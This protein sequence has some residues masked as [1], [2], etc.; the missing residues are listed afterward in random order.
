VAVGVAGTRHLTLVAFLSS[1]CGTC[2]GFWEAFSRGAPAELGDVRLVVVTHGPERESPAEVARL[3]PPAV[4]TV[5]SSA[6]F[7]DYAVPVSPYFIL[8]DGPNSRVAGEGAAATWPQV[9][10]L[11][12]Q[13]TGDS[14]DRTFDLRDSRDRDARAEAELAAAGIGPG[15][16]SLYPAPERRG[17]DR[18]T[19]LPEEA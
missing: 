15:H 9:A 18:I 3:A 4:T 11:L 13:A 2:G 1:G 12:A 5:M 17:A 7:D 10:N 14:S 6:A 16:P 19:E 8:V